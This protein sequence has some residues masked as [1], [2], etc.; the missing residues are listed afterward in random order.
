MSGAASLDHVGIVG[1]DLPNLAVAFERIG[2]CLTPSARHAG[3]RTGNRCAMLRDGGYLELVAVLPGGA[4]AT[5]E[6]F[7]ARHAGAHIAALTIADPAAEAVRLERAGVMPVSVA[8]TDRAVD[9]ADPAA[10]HARFTLVMPPDQPEGRF[11]LVCQRTPELLWQER[12]LHHPNHAAG[13]VAVALAVTDP[14]ETACRLSRLAGRPMLPDPLG[15]YAL[16]LPRGTVRLLSVEACAALF[17][18]TEPASAPS[19]A[20]VAVATDDGNA[21]IGRVVEQAGLPYRRD[22]AA[23][24]LHVAGV[25]LR[26]VPMGE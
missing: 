6:R 23:V 24:V 7:L 20:G 17:P 9:D 2:F 21:A 5:L 25:G 26:F 22:D 13:L 11:L 18:G 1:S 8:D 4:S 10:P 12:F 15:G 14:A 16:D 19:I 3:G